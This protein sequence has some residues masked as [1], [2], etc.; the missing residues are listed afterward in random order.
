MIMKENTLLTLE[1]MG[2]DAQMNI[3]QLVDD[4]VKG[5]ARW[6]QRY[7]SAVLGKEVSQRQTRLIVEAQVAFVLMVFPAA[8]SLL[9]RLV[10]VGWFVWSLMR[11]H[12]SGI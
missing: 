4:L 10:F 6:L 9:L 8:F 12:K 7:F 1:P 11:C 3:S 5:P 2:N